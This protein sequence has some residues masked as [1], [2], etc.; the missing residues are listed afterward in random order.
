MQI[1][2]CYSPVRHLYQINPA[3][4]V[5]RGKKKKKTK[6]QE[7]ILIRYHFIYIPTLLHPASPGQAFAAGIGFRV[8]CDIICFF[9][10]ESLALFL[11]SLLCFCTHK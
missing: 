5:N 9:K 4:D 11:F 3:S 10:E 6:K 7:P 8:S 1:Y 2:Q